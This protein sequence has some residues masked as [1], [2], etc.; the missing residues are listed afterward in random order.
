MNRNPV[1]VLIL[2][3]L[4]HATA[5]AQGATPPPLTLDAAIAEALVNNPTLVALR[6]EL[7]VVRRRPAQDRALAPPTLEAAI[8]Q[9]PLDTLNPLNTN[10]Y[11][12]TAR[13]DIPG[14]GKRTLR[15]AVT[16]K[17]V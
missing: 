16:D 14:S 13:Q 15:A 8:W 9:W 4:F 12:F 11:M 17:D 5:F 3:L 1:L 10:M 6:R 2:S 7:D